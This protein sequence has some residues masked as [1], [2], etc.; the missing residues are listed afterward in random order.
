MKDSNPAG[1]S[2]AQEELL[3]AGIP[4]ADLARFKDLRLGSLIPKLGITF[5]RLSAQ[6]TLAS[7]PVAGNT[8]P[9]GL[10][11]GGASAALMETVGSF[12]SSM[13]GTEETVALGTELNL[14]HL[15]P[16]RSGLVTARAWALK[17][18]RTLCIHQLEV[19]DEKDRLIST[20]RMTNMLVARAGLK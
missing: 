6:E 17:L 14:S 20:G 12:A 3:A 18:G 11:H 7:M 9:A 13:A 4:A 5:I 15:R 8:Q 19:R 16:A 1:Y 10:L 2:P